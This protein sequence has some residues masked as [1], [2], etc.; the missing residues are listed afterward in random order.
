MTPGIPEDTTVCAP[1]PWELVGDNVS[2]GLGGWFIC[3]DIV[4][5]DELAGGGGCQ[6][7]RAL[8]GAWR[9]YIPAHRAQ[10]GT[11][12]SKKGLEGLIDCW[13]SDI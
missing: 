4:R 8:A 6:N 12:S 11:Q 10:D 9:V 13:Y 1:L 2:E 5:N 3:E 7:S